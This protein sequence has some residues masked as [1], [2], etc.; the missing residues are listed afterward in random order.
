MLLYESE[1]YYVALTCKGAHWWCEFELDINSVIIVK[2]PL[3]LICFAQSL[4]DTNLATQGPEVPY[5]QIPG[6]FGYWGQPFFYVNHVG[7]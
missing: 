6:L 5:K 4:L 7:M 1:V 3:D 2:A